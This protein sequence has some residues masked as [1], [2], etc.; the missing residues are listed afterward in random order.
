M[1]DQNKDLG[2]QGQE[3]TL[4]GKMNKAAGK[5]ESTAGDVFGNESMKA[6]GEAKQAGGSVQ[7]TLGK[8]ERKVDDALD[9]IREDNARTND[10]TTNY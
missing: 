9:N 2:T 6:K 4:K 7:S 10:T 3:D 1:D 8:G 5:V